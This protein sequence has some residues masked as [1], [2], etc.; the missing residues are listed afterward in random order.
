ML[1]RFALGR[2]WGRLAPTV[3]VLG[4]LA[5]AALAVFPYMYAV[6]K[7][8]DDERVFLRNY[9]APNEYEA[10]ASYP[11]S[12][13]TGSH[14]ANDVV[15]VGDSSLRCDVRTT[16]FEGETGL[17]AYNL[18]NAG[19]IG[20]RGQTQIIRTYLSNHPKPRLAVV[21]ILPTAFDF[22][23][24]EFRPEEERDVRSRFLWCYG[25]GTENMRPHSS[26]LYHV[27]QGIKYTYGVLA[28]GFDRFAREPI[29]FRD[30]ETFRS[31]EQAVTRERGFWAPPPR[32]MVL[33]V[34]RKHNTSGEA[35]PISDQFKKDF[36]ALL[37][38]LTDAQVSVL[39]RLT[40]S[41]DATE[42]PAPAIRAW[43]EDVESR[44]PLVTVAKPEVL[45]YDPPLFFDVSHLNAEGALKFTK[46][47]SA[48]VKR[49]L[50]K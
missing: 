40:P 2:D 23:G 48:E 8:H 7:R 49:V 33:R 20:I 38:V 28:G 17:K 39:I 22:S 24:E 1:A 4:I 18:G 15:F 36:A 11:M 12:Y 37:G 16:Q 9:R 42:E 43:S 50:A 46:L 3:T 6:G 10:F 27:R 32:R 25:P 44:N 29:S 21:C 45:V 31:L 13:A 19:L 26:Y 41:L 30:G 47:V 35:Y 5:A 14:E 34:T